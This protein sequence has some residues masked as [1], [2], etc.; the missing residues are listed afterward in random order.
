MISQFLK[1]P[2]AFLTT[3]PLNQYP[4]NTVS[5]SIYTDSPAL[6][7]T[8]LADVVGSKTVFWVLRHA[9]YNSLENTT[10]KL[11]LPTSRGNYSIAA[12]GGSLQ[13]S[14]RDSKIHL[15]DYDL[16][17]AYKILYSSGEVFTWKKFASKTI[18]L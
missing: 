11:Q 9:A 6:A 1:A 17:G 16:G 12:L 7:V 18:V 14:G 3:R 2:P 8:Q 4:V 10:Y 5:A 13:V 15:S